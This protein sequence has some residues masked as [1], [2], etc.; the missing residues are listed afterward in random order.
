[1]RRSDFWRRPIYMWR[2]YIIVWCL[3]ITSFHAHSLSHT[4]TPSRMDWKYEMN[5]SWWRWQWE[6]F[7]LSDEFLLFL[8]FSDFSRLSLNEYDAGWLAVGLAFCVWLSCNRILGE[9]VSFAWFFFFSSP[10]IHSGSF[11]LFHL[12]RII[13]V[14][15]HNAARR[16]CEDFLFAKFLLLNFLLLLLLLLHWMNGC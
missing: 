14:V 3:S 1:M 10:L 2:M 13:C 9:I 5:G 8:L 16:H 6:N 15:L 12:C 4:H 11:S 7:V